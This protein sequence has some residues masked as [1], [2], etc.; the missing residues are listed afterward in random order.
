[1]GRRLQLVVE[2]Y[3]GRTILAIRDLSNIMAGGSHLSCWV[4]EESKRDITEFVSS[5]AIAGAQQW[6]Q[7]YALSSLVFRS[8]YLRVRSLRELLEQAQ[9]HLARERARTYIV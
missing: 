8:R 6:R 4:H 3:D 5:T 1:M 2:A 7:M 9:V